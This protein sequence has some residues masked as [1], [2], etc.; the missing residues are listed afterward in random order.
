MKI[1][2]SYILYGLLLVIFLSAL[3]LFKLTGLRVFLGYFFVLIF[4]TYLILKLFDMEQHERI[5]FSFFLGL[6]ITTLLVW[7]VDRVIG[8]LSVSMIVTAALLYIVYGVV[9][10][11]RKKN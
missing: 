4:P 11:L 9:Y 10:Y 3:Y 2:K 5:F 7:Y 1:K 8:K 6:I